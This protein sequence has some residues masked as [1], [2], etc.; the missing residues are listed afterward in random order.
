MISKIVHIK[1]QWGNADKVIVKRNIQSEMLI[2]EV[3][4]D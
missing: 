3:K 1:V 2:L 4:N